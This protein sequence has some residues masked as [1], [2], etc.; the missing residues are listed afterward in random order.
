[1]TTLPASTDRDLWVSWDDYHRL[2]E[3][4]TLAVYESGWSFDV[5]LC[6]ARGG[7]RVG[8]VISRIFEV[9]LGIL[10]ASSYRAAAGTQQ[11]ELDIAPFITHTKL[12]LSEQYAICQI[13]IKY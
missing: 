10:A 4:L 12:I 7:M 5:I 3:Q 11:G 1:M 13:A 6:L 2:I 8:D 9:P